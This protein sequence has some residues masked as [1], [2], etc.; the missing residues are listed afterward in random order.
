MPMYDYKCLAGI[1]DHVRNIEE[2]AGLLDTQ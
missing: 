1:A 2:I